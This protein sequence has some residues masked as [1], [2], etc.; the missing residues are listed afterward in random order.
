MEPGGAVTPGRD[1]AD[2]AIGRTLFQAYAAELGVDL[3]F[4]GFAEELEKLPALYGPPRGCLL[5]A[6]L[7]GEPVGCVGLRDRGDGVCEMKRLYVRPDRRGSGL[8]RV[9]AGEI[10][11]KARALGYGRIVLDT[12]PSMERA[13]ALYRA[14][15]FRPGEAYYANPLP[16]VIYL[17]LEL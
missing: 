6:R 16:G 1:E 11:A 15:G 5:L 8:G 4:Q 7:E 3:C 9:L 2:Y 12:L 17:S 14:L 10:I 13:Q